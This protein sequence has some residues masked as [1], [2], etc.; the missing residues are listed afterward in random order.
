MIE[1]FN[2]PIQ[3]Q[4]SR[5]HQLLAGQAPL[6]GLRRIAHAQPCRVSSMWGQFLGN[7]TSFLSSQS[8]I[9]P[10]VHGYVWNA[11]P[12]PTAPSFSRLSWQQLLTFH[13]S[14]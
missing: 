9:L 8:Q 4:S 12:L 1:T 11:P 7:K 3:L 13:L 10:H 5:Q 6:I 14:Y 2:S